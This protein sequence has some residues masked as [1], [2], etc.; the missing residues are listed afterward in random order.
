MNLASGNSSRSVLIR[1]LSAQFFITS[2][3]PP[4]FNVALRKIVRYISAHLARVDSGRLSKYV[5][6]FSKKQLLLRRTKKCLAAAVVDSVEADLAVVAFVEADS[7]V[8]VE[9]FEL[10]V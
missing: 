6:Y 3:F 5:I 10:E 1:A 8:V 2:R 7:V 4:V 9:A